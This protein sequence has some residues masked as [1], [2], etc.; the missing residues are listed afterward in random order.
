MAS[1]SSQDSEVATILQES[2]GQNPPKP[3]F[4]VVKQYDPRGEWTLHRLVPS[5]SFVCRQCNR[6][7]K[8]KLVATRHSR[9]DD[10]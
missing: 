1:G 2:S 8:A 9:W 6:Q 7:K 4:E 3:P 5:T 10:L